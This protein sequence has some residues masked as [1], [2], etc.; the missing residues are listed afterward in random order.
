MK[1]FLICVFSFF[2]FT[3]NAQNSEGYFLSQPSLTPDGKTVIFSFEGDIWRAEVSGGQAYRLTAMQ[4]YES[5]AKV[6]PD[7]KWIAFTGR[8][9]GNPD[10]Y[11][12]PVGGG[13]IKQITFHSGSD[14]VNSWSWDSK[15]IYFT[16][17]RLGQISGFKVSLNG[18]TPSR[19][20]GDYFFQYDHNLFE[21]PTTGEI[22]FND[23]WESSSQIARKRYKGPFN[24][25]IESYNPR[26]KKFT[27]YT[28]W[29]GKDFGATIDKNGNIY[30][31][32]DEANGEFN[33]YTIEKGKSVGLTNFNTSIKSPIVNA[34]G[35]KVVFERDYQLW[36]FDVATKKAEK[37][38]I[39]IIRNSI[40]S[41]EKDF[42]VRNNITNYDV[43]P[44]G[45]N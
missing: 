1:Y 28:T 33:L 8:Q 26:T 16:S 4:G 20:F 9:Y 43:S 45:K 10:V 34:N 40:L 13:D 39:P 7:G 5:N 36:I 35:G 42:D 2:F 14:D 6:S 19:V 32:S 23:T 27:K 44:D 25:D 41:Q 18:G 38:N 15:W 24:P 21:H 30:F 12:M 31:I 37:L 22:F 17:T 3:S 29:E 11:L